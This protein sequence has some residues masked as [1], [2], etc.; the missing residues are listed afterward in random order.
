MAG[1]PI[2]FHLPGSVLRDPGALLKPYYRR[3][4]EGLRARG[5]AVE[6]AVHDR[7]LL[8]AQVEA[9][10]AFHIVDHG[11]H[12]HP[13]VLNTGVA[14]VYP[15][16]H[17][18]PWGIRALS[19]IGAKRFDPAAVDGGEAA[20]FA[21]RLRRRLVAA[22]TSRYP[23]PEARGDVPRGCIA[24][25]LQSEA[26]RGV[27]ETCHLTLRQMVRSVLDRP[28]PR[29]VVIKPHPR[30]HAPATRRFLARLAE[31]DAR[32]QVLDANI[33]DILAVADAVVTINSAV[34]IEAMLHRRPVVLC[35]RADFHHCAVTVETPGAMA[36]ALARAEATA[37]PHDAYLWW[38]FGLN[39]LNAGR[40]TLV[41]DFLARIA[42]AGFDLARLGAA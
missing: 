3:L 23:Q 25:F 14:Y 27:G 33:H 10:R 18:D 9:D 31:R 42:A 5:V 24:V 7:A 30:D 38:Y 32:V 6:F 29:P 1:V 35:G 40:P 20:A 11:T 34:G 15:F 8:P 2:V 36:A 22:R 19:S 26:H 28:D 41:E 16:W 17:L 13:R 39:C 21:D 4:D 12:R 37:W